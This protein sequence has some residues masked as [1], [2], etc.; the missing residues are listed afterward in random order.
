MDDYL[1]VVINIFEHGAQHARVRRTI[2]VAALIQEVLNQFDDIASETP[3]KYAL[4]LKDADRPLW[5]TFSLEKLDIQPHDELNFDY[6]HQPI[7]KMLDPAN[8]A[9]LLNDLSGNTYEI[10]WQPAVIGRPTSDASHNLILSVNLQDLP[11]SITVSHK[12][13]QITFS[14]GHFYLEPL[15]ENNPVFLNGKEL[16]LNSRREIK[17]GDKIAIGKHKIVMTFETQ[18]DDSPTQVDAI[19]P[20]AQMTPINPKRAAPEKEKT[21][22]EAAAAVPGSGEAPAAYLVI[23]TCSV[24]ENIGQKLIPDQYPFILGRNLPL[25]SGENEI[26]RRHAEIAYDPQTKQFSVTDLKSTNGVSVDGKHIEP[27]KPMEITPG[28]KIGLG[29]IVTLRLKN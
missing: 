28:S 19:P 25:L 14:Q 3:E 6:I 24:M 2:T 17:R 29:K 22:P 13:A 27:E 12:H 7:K 1:D 16:P 9:S 20:A 15:A 11:N 21:R 26:S 23:E 4:Y 8:F 18:R 5:S 10:Q